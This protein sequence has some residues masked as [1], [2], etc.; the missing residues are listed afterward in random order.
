MTQEQHDYIRGLR[1]LADLF[2][3]VPDLVPSNGLR[4]D[5]WPGTK[6]ALVAI[7]KRIGGKAEKEVGTYSELFILRWWFGP[8]RLE[9]NVMK[10]E[11]CE[12]IVTGMREVQRPNPDAPLMT[13]MEEIVEWRCSDSLLRE[14]GA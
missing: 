6:E 2:E 10:R 4:V 1:D 11:T 3:R 14:D 5:L 8:H 7:A 9:A 12:R 13:V